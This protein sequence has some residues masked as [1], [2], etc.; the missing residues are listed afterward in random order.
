MYR[1]NKMIGMLFLGICLLVSIVALSNYW[2]INTS[3]GKVYNNMEDMPTNDVGLVLGANPK[4]FNKY[5]N[6]YFYNRIDAAE[7]LYKSG[8]VKHLLLSGDNGNRAYNEPKAMKEALMNRGVPESAITLDFAGFR[9]LD[10]VVRSQKIF[11]QKKITVLSQEFHNYR[12]LFIADHYG[13]DAVAF[14]AKAVNSG[15]QKTIYR[16]YLARF[17]AV[18]DLYILRKQPKFLGDKIDIVI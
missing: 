18:L 8:K 4:I 16:E 3:K 2:L 13:I 1:L 7:K 6:P 17:K 5:D 15:S 14:N 12:A 11:Q 9:T 10:S